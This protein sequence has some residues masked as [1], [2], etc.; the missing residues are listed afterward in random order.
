MNSKF[1]NLLL[2]I[3]VYERLLLW[4]ALNF[5]S[6]FFSSNLT[7]L[8]WLLLNFINKRSATTGDRRVRVARIQRRP[9]RHTEEAAVGKELQDTADFVPW[10]IPTAAAAAVRG[11]SEWVSESSPFIHPR[12]RNRLL[13]SLIFGDMRLNW[14]STNDVE[15]SKIPRGCTQRTSVH[16]CWYNDDEGDFWSQQLRWAHSSSERHAAYWDR[17]LTRK[18]IHHSF[19]CWYCSRFTSKWS[20]QQI[21]FFFNRSWGFPNNEVFTINLNDPDPYHKPVH[22]LRLR[23]AKSSVYYRLIKYAFFFI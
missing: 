6:L 8:Y 16:I 21:W 19:N 22:F 12:P 17:S 11:L 7:L 14:P 2:N 15:G 4:T 5:I 9:S 23:R 20:Y 3:S 1:L 18:I 13:W 10:A